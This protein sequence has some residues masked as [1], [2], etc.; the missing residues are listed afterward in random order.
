MRPTGKIPRATPGYVNGAA[1]VPAEGC[2]ATAGSDAAVVVMLGGGMSMNTPVTKDAS[3]FDRVVL[4]TVPF[5]KVPERVTTG[6]T[7]II[8]AVLLLISI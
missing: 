3:V 1:V 5:A 6:M 8:I 7:A 4:S 2:V